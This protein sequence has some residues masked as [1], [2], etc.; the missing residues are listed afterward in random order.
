MG[1]YQEEGR[2]SKYICYKARGFFPS[3][4]IAKI[5]VLEIMTRTMILTLRSYEVLW[6]EQS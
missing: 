2:A 1:R 6:P 4:Y 5:K 3:M